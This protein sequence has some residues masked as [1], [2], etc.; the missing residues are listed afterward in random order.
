MKLEELKRLGY[1]SIEDYRCSIIDT[2][3]IFEKVDADS[4]ETA[5]ECMKF[6]YMNEEEVPQVDIKNGFVEI[7]Y[8]NP[9]TGRTLLLQCKGNDIY[10]YRYHWDKSYQKPDVI[11]RE[12][13]Y[14]AVNLSKFFFSHK[15]DRICLFTGAFNPPTIAHYHMIDS[16]LEAGGFN[17]I[18][19][20]TSNQ[21]FL[22]RK[23]KKNGGWSYN[24][25]ERIRFL[26]AMTKNHPKVLVFGA[27][28][29]YTYDVLCQVKERYQAK[30]VYFAI[31]SD[32]L[33]EMDR[34]GHSKELLSQFCFYVLQRNDT[35]EYIQFMCNKL[36]G[37]TD[38]KIGIDNQ[39][40]KDISATEVRRRIKEGEDYSM[41]VTVDVFSE[42]QEIKEEKVVL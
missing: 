32:K 12:N 18:V 35:M 39:D 17:Y 22:D 9:D 19:F 42:L 34:W 1:K 33:K 3:P 26:L 8:K 10:A 14:K 24:E 7:Q 13:I 29:G 25:D 28:Q 16:A 30:D 41:L 6:L 4:K 15:R 11:P 37:L 27:E 36:F 40:F 2:L 38:Y 21:A 23:Q 31:G 5:M 20:A